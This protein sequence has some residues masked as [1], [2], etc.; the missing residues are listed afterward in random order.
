MNV[1]QLKLINAM[2]LG[3]GSLRTWKTAKHYAYAFSQIATHKDY[4]DYQAN[5]LDGLSKV[6]IRWYD[7]RRD[8][9]G[10]H[11]QPHYT[12]ETGVHPTFTALYQRVYVNK[13]KS[14]SLHD[15]K[16][17]D[18]QCAAIWYMDDGY[19]LKS[20]FSSHNGNVFLCTDNFSHSEV[21]VL[22]K[23]LYEKL[24]LPFHVIRRGKRK[25]GTAVYRLM[26][27]NQ[28]AE[29]FCDIVSPYILPSFAYKLHSKQSTPLG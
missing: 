5:I 3:D 14:I 20:Q 29:R 12:L 2:L 9:N 13:R 8:K 22:Q 23:M 28:Y 6:T 26:V 11:H 1:E 21:I 4:V 10:V 17:F 27:R 18:A 25:D 19:R 24:Q 15:L 7:A 16:T